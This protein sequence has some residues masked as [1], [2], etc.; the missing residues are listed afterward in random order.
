MEPDDPRLAN[1]R[2]W[3]PGQS[4]NPSGRTKSAALSRA[5]R[6]ELDAIDPVSGLP[7]SQAIAKTLVR[8]ALN[9]SVAAARLLLETTE[10]K[11]FKAAFSITEET[12]YEEAPGSAKARLLQKL[13]IALAAHEQTAPT[14]DEEQ[15]EQEDNQQEA[16]VVSA[17]TTVGAADRLRARL[18]TRR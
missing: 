11:L 6:Q 2:P 15:D 12:S 5:C 7:N 18:E 8:E 16:A 13:C 3:Q 4:G 17:N 1:L 14:V 10:G 9:G